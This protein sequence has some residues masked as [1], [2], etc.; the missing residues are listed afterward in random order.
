MGPG[1]PDLAEGER[2]GLSA[3]IEK[4]DLG[5]AV[6]DGAGLPDQLM[7]PAAP[8]T[9]VRFNVRIDRH[10]PGAAHGADVDDEGSGTVA[11]QRLHLTRS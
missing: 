5:G 8:G 1:L 6:G 9:S 7:G 11:E 2:V 3:R 4:G 10:P